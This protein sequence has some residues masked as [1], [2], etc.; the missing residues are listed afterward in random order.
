LRVRQ[1]GHIALQHRRCDDVL[2]RSWE[3]ADGL[4]RFPVSDDL[5]M[6]LSSPSADTFARRVWVVLLEDLFEQDKALAIFVELCFEL[7]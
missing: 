1:L 2:A 6:H 5:P 4:L 3:A 7:S